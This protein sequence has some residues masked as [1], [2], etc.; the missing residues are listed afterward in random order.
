MQLDSRR[1]DNSSQM[2]TCE[3]SPQN[4][5]L[6]KGV[7]EEEAD[8]DWP[9]NRYIEPTVQRS[10]YWFILD[11]SYTKPHSQFYIYLCL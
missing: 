10:A 3:I 6:L 7:L 1:P 11:T 9:E 4:V 5:A 8:S 2:F